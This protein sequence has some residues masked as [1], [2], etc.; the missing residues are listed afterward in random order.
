[1]WMT[2]ERKLF[3]VQSKNLIIMK[4]KI[5]YKPWVSIQMNEQVSN[6]LNKLSTYS[7]LRS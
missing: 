3:S 1:M 7:N 6:L 4:S 2:L 5:I